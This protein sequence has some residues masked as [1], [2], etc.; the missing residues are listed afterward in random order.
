M[1]IFQ[2]IVLISLSSC[3]HREGVDFP[4]GD[5]SYNIALI[6]GHGYFVPDYVP[7]YL[8]PNPAPNFTPTGM[9]TGKP[10]LPDSYTKKSIK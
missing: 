3:A 2:I 4:V 7:D 5:R 8:P 1:K 6:S 9:P 10:S